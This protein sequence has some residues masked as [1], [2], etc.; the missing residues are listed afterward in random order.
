MGW[1]RDAYVNSYEK[2]VEARPEYNDSITSNL[3]NYVV[4]AKDV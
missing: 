1:E 2:E 4:F 3:R